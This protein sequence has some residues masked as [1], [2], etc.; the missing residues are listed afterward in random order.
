MLRPADLRDVLDV[1]LQRHQTD[2][3]TARNTLQTALDNDKVVKG[4]KYLSVWAL[5]FELLTEAVSTKIKNDE[6]SFSLRPS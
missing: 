2:L 3:K 4:L 1:D 5:C 6:Y